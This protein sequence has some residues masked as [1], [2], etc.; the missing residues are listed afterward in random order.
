MGVASGLEFQF[1]LR[2]LGVRGL[3]VDGGDAGVA[4]RQVRSGGS[5]E[6]GDDDAFVLECLGVIEGRLAKG[7]MLAA[8]DADD[9]GHTVGGGELELISG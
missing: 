2:G 7:G 3:V 5:A 8:F 9:P 6:G 1:E 4:G